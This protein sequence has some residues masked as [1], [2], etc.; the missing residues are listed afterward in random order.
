MYFDKCIKTISVNCSEPVSEFVKRF[1]NSKAGFYCVIDNDQRL[2]GVISLGD[3]ARNCCFADKNSKKTVSEIMNTNYHSLRMGASTSTLIHFLEK[4]RFVPLTDEFNKLKILVKG[5]PNQ[6]EFYLGKHSIKRD[7]NYLLIAE[8][9]NNHNGSIEQAYELIRSA[10]ESGAHIAKFQMRDLNTLYGDIE[11]S[12]DLSTEYVINLLKKVSLSDNDM[13]RCFDF[14]KELG[15]TPLCTPFDIASLKKLEEYGL[16]GYKVASADLTNHELLEEL[17]KTKKPLIV[18]TGMSTDEDIDQAISLLEKS[19]VNYVLCHANSTYPVPFSDI[20]LNYIDNLKARTASVIGYSGHERGWH[21][22]LAAFMKGAQVIEKHFTLDKTLEGNDHKVSLLPYEFSAMSQ[23]FSDL[24]EALGV[25]YKRQITQGE[26][27]NRVALAKSIFSRKDIKQGDVIK[28][29]DLIVRSPGNGLS[30]RMKSALIGRPAVR[31]ISVGEP[32]FEGDLKDL[33]DEEKLLTPDNYKWCIPVRH[34]DVYELYDI[35]KPPAIEFH[36]S[37]KDLDIDDEK[38]L[39][40]TLDSEI[41]VHAPEQFD[42]DFVLDLFSDDPDITKKS[43]ELLKRIFLKAKKISELSGYT[44]RPKVVVNCGGHTRDKFLSVDE[45][46]RRINNFSNNIQKVDTNGC[47]FLAQTMPP[48]PWHFGG[49]A[50]HN[51]FTSAENIKKIL[52]STQKEVELCLDISHS[53]MWCNFSGQDLEGFIGEI[54]SNVTHIHIS[55]S[56]GESEEG[57]QIG[58][59]TLDFK[60]IRKALAELSRDSTLLPEVWQ[61]HDNGGQGF[62]TALQRLNVLGF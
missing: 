37:F 34:R 12:H 51:Q 55:D 3:I 50:F 42:G 43:I 48:Y 20:H 58:E 10:E 8:I 18:S 44:G 36:L 62:R 41:I 35:F 1:N 4:Y 9:G 52:A 11:G 19:Y 38:V 7:E 61:G 54:A 2:M 24:S 23:A 49:Q 39:K 32:F 30:P 16:E 22:P 59:G 28:E 53:Y 40:R 13:Y 46:N 45:V 60:M 5:L 21:V 56:S 47:R 57:L 31:E 17:V 26:A 15:L 25:G 27:T 14:C 33:A 29:A 6:R